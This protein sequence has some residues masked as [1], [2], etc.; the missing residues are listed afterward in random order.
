MREQSCIY[1]T[2]TGPVLRSQACHSFI[3][4]SLVLRCCYRIWGRWMAKMLRYVACRVMNQAQSKLLFTPTPAYDLIGT[5]EN[6]W[7]EV[8]LDHATW[9]DHTLRKAKSAL[10]HKTSPTLYIVDHLGSHPSLSVCE[11]SHT[12]AQNNN[13]DNTAQPP[14]IQPSLKSKFDNGSRI[15]VW[16]WKEW[17]NSTY[18]DLLA[19][20]A[21]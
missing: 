10:S 20:D 18:L 17:D 4:D 5:Y 19:I 13:K 15:Y 11:T 16:L 7:S 6:W 8:D 2:Y 12:A 1:S 9:S 21:P 3:Y 14:T